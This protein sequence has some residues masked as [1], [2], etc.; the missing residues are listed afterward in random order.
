[1]VS[2]KHR[3]ACVSSDSHWIFDCCLLCRKTICKSFCKNYLH[4]YI[5][6]SHIRYG[7]L[8]ILVRIVVYTT[9]QLSV[10][11]FTSLDPACFQPTF[12]EY[13][14]SKG[15]TAMLIIYTLVELGCCLYR[16]SWY[17]PNT[18]VSILQFRC[19]CVG[20]SRETV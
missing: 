16:Y 18:F 1:M 2:N 20:V 17:G 7:F 6:K 12:Y 19:G 9:L 3:H 13:H 14:I 8:I 5:S 15:Y 4:P 11:Y 10:I